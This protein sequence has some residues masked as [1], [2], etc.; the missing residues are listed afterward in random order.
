MNLQNMGVSEEEIVELVNFVGKWGKQ[1]LGMG[2]VSVSNNNGNS[3]DGNK[4]WKLD[5]KLNI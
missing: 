2:Q 1:W 4:A 5:D 3:G